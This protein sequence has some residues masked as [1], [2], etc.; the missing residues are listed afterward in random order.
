MGIWISAWTVGEY[1][2]AKYGQGG[3]GRTIE[4]KELTGQWIKRHRAR[5]VMQMSVAS[6]S[7]R[8]HEKEWGKGILVQGQ[9]IWTNSAGDWIS[10]WHFQISAHTFLCINNIE[11]EKSR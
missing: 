2:T 6:V 10:Y 11:Y 8:P 9:A 5:I 1:G 7:A 4:L 3:K